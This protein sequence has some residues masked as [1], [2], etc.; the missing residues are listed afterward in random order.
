MLKKL[1][2]FAFVLPMICLSLVACSDDDSAANPVVITALTEVSTIDTGDS[3]D[4]VAHGEYLYYTGSLATANSFGI[5][6]FS[7]P[8]NPTILGT[9][10]AGNAYGIDFDGRYAFVETDGGGDGIFASGTV[11]VID[12]LDPNNPVTVM[13][14]DLGYSSAYDSEL[15]GNYYYNLSLSIIGVYDVSDPTAIQHVRNIPTTDVYFGRAVGDYLYV[16][17]NGDLAIFD[18]SNPA[19]STSEV[20]SLAIPSVSTYGGAT[21]KGATAFISGNDGDERIYSV[22]VTDPANPAILSSLIVPSALNNEMRILGNYLLVSGG[23]EFAAIDISDPAN[24]VL[25][26][27]VAMG[28]NDGWGFDIS[29]R[30]AIVGDYTVLRV[31]QLY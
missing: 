8:L 7:D 14:N 15:S 17:D 25:V 13:E 16:K 4:V 1:I 3:A 30:Y 6:D 18:I 2:N 26:D 20:G 27:T 21:A 10:A 31:I 11:G 12:A 23:Y 19:V 29:G 24:M 5:V 9:L 22:D 28:N